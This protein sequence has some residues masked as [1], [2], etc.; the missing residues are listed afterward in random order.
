M[1]LLR[2]AA[3]PRL[4]RTLAVALVAPLLL[5]AASCN[6]GVECLHCQDIVSTIPW[7]APEAHTYTLTQDG[8]TKGKITLSISEDGDIFALEQNSVDDKGNSDISVVRADQQTL[9]P[10][11]YHREVIDSAQKRVVDVTYDD[12][13][14]SKCKTGRQA[15]ITQTTFDPPSRSEPNS[16]RKIPVCVPENSYE[17]DSSLFLWRTIKFEK[18]WT[19][20]YRTMLSNRGDERQT[21]VI[22]VVGQQKL[23]VGGTDVDTWLVTMEADQSQQRGWFAATPDHRLLRYSNG[24]LTFDITE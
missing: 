11:A 22:T 6:T 15:Q 7:T 12:I 17:N 21:V 10:R 14:T 9:K 2:R 20:N 13:D 5:L 16:T 4:I 18:G 24:S 8:Q 3:R 1:T 19:A 23:K